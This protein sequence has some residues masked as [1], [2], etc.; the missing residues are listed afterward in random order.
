MDDSR[1]RI[2]VADALAIAEHFG[3]CD[4]CCEQHGDMP[5]SVSCYCDCHR[6]QEGRWQAI[7]KRWRELRWAYAG[8]V[9]TAK[10]W[11]LYT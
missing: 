4:N 11:E 10:R 9:K 5:S 3:G 2:D 6:G 1:G 8:D 7:Q